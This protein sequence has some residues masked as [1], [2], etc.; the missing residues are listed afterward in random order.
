MYLMEFTFVFKSFHRLFYVHPALFNTVNVAFS[1]YLH[2]LY[3]YYFYNLLFTMYAFFLYDIFLFKAST[4]SDNI[5]I[6]MIVMQVVKLNLH[7]FK[8]LY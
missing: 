4:I 3:D 2:Y 5:D 6:C 7:Q 1:W 8:L